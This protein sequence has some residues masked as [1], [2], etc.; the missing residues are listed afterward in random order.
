M[1]ATLQATYT[2]DATN[3][4]VNASNDYI[5]ITGNS[6]YDD[7]Y[8]MISAIPAA[9]RITVLHPSA[10]TQILFLDNLQS[11]LEEKLQ[12]VLIMIPMEL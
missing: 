8:Y 6:Q 11:K 1:W 7:Q 4:I 3:G 10:S 12:L 9:N 5:Q 2:L